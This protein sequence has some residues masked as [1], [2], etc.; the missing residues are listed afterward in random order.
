MTN[1]GASPP[2]SRS[3]PSS[4]P[5]CRPPAPYIAAIGA[6]RIFAR[7][8]SLVGSIGVII[9]YPNFATLLDKIGVKLEEVKS[10]P[11]KAAPNGMTPTSDA[12]RAAM[13]ALVADSFDWST[14][15]WSRS[16][17]I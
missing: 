2:R 16:V 14:R 12:A 15:R 7:G 6:D 13:A 17:A 10:S 1:N 4:A 8:N 3:S 11:L 9:E 5:W